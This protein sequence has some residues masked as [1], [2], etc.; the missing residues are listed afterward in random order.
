LKPQYSV[1]FQLATGTF[2][3]IISRVTSEMRAWLPSAFTTLFRVNAEHCAVACGPDF[4]SDRRDEFVASWLRNEYESALIVGPLEFARLVAQLVD[5]GLPVALPVDGDGAAHPLDREQAQAVPR[6][7]CVEV[8][9][10]DG[11]QVS[12]PLIRLAGQVDE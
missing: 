9:C 3:R 10:R 8:G 11:D 6:P 2:P 4:T 7:E 5:A 12:K 1:T